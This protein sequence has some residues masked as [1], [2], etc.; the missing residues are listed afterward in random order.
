MR[1]PW[2]Y[3][4]E[5][6][7]LRPAAQ[8]VILRH[9]KER[10]RASNSGLIT[11][12]AM[13][14]SQLV[15]LGAPDSPSTPELG[16]DGDWLLF[17]G[18]VNLPPPGALRRLIVLDG[19][20][21]QCRSMFGRLTKLH[22]MPRLSLPPPTRPPAMR[23]RSQQREDGMAT[24]EA[25]AEALDALGDLESAQG[26]RALYDV[27]ARQHLASRGGPAAIGP[28][29]IEPASA[30][31]ESGESSLDADADDDQGGS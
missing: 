2:C 17:P 30:G 7:Q 28:A 12:H 18:P 5:I 14:G 23:M 4:A 6:P 10:T 24:M 11:H 21:S 25:I 16:L 22:T 9:V 3:C 27:M 19:S 20:W 26:L 1:Q 15:D 13:P 29:S 8:V 31:L